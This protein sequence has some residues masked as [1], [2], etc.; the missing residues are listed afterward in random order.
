MYEKNCLYVQQL[1]VA[2]DCDRWC[3]QNISH[4]WLHE[5]INKTIGLLFFAFSCGQM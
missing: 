3:I 5:M 4:G 2:K 1:S